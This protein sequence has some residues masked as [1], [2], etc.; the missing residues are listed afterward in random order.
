MKLFSRI[1]IDILKKEKCNFVSYHLRYKIRN[2][3]F[4]IL[5]QHLCHVLSILTRVTV[6]V[7]MLLV[8][9][10]SQKKLFLPLTY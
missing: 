4:H 6:G 5:S 8:N 10:Y 1:Y 9:I 3:I 7:C 2:T